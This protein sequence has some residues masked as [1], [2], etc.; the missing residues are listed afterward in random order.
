MTKWIYINKF[1][2][3]FFFLLFWFIEMFV[4]LSQTI[5]I[6][7]K[8]MRKFKFNLKMDSAWWIEEMA[9]STWIIKFLLYTGA[10]D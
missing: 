5:L 1:Q 6:A 7:K 3:S 9:S 2:K 4:L 8:E 10:T